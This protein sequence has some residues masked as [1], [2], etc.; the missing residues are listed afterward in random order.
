MPK[1]LKMRIVLMLVGFMA[2]YVVWAVQGRQAYAQQQAVDRAAQAERVAG[3]CH[4]RRV[5]NDYGIARQE[6][7]VAGDFGLCLNVKMGRQDFPP[8]SVCSD[9]GSIRSP[10]ADMPN[11]AQCAVSEIESYFRSW[12]AN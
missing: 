10:P 8:A 1:N 11:I 4:I 6:C 3:I 5:C 12:K 2:C 7:A 9:D